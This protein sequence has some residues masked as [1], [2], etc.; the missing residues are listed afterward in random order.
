MQKPREEHMEAARRV[1]R[2]L[3]GTAGQGILLRQTCNL[4][5]TGFCDA[6]WGACPL[7]R[8]SLTG[9]FMMLGDSP[10]SW[11]TKKQS[12]VSRSSVEAEYRSMAV[13]TSELVWL[14]TFLAALGIFLP[15]LC[16]YSVIVKQVCI[17]L[18]IQLIMNAPSILR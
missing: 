18:T 10:I 17:S 8:K 11:K 15:S 4:Q 13:A 12:T 6:D 2:Y 16:I 3:K 1:V 14:R 5:L 7:S 9:Y